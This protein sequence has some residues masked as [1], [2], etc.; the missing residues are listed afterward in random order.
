MTRTQTKRKLTAGL[1][2]L[3]LAMSL[4]PAHA[5]AEGYLD[6][7]A[8]AWYALAVTGCQENGLMDPIEEHAFF[9]SWMLTR[10]V[11]AEALYR[12]EGR[13]QTEGDLPFTDVPESHVN[14]DA[15]RWAVQ[16]G[17][18]SGYPDGTF[19][20]G[21]P[22]RREET[23]VL[24]W[25]C[26]GKAEAE[27]ETY[28]DQDTISS[29]ALP[30][31]A[32]ARSMKV[33]QGTD[34]NL[35]QPQEYTTRAQAASLLMGYG[36]AFYGLALPEAPAVPPSQD[37]DVPPSQNTDV[38][39]PSITTV[40]GVSQ[41]IRP[42]EYVNELFVQDYRGYLSYMG[43]V[44]YQGVDVSA[45]QEDIDWARVAAAGT[46]F[47]MIRA[48][49][50]GYT[51]GTINK[52]AYF[53]RNIRGA[54]A[55][56][57]QV[58]VYFFSQAITPQEAQEEAYQLLEWIRGYDI[59]Y[60]VVFDWEVPS[61]EA[62]T[63]YVDGA[64]ATACARAFCQVVQNAGYIPMTYGSPKKIYDGKLMLDQLQDYPAFW[65][66]NYTA[67]RAPTTFLY[68]YDMWQYSSTGHVDG[69]QGDVDLNV[70]LTDWSN[71]R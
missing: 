9:P 3:I 36:T 35:F 5:A 39:P 64:T 19:R 56:G 45:H 52:D 10:G 34:Q 55:N 50:R 47:A 11:V 21:A 41:D 66:A 30:A 26:Q 31:V 16:A 46:D 28:L 37:T 44:S 14:A 70:C 62:R 53:E 61:D 51:A 67:G 17:V 23:A 60:P 71:W 20:P 68:H 59:T 57:L 15:I 69:I 25:S 7:P 22:I 8:D 54:L 24:L 65:L 43:G 49:F 58:G 33:M 18:V 2:A 6:V 32:W 12:L 1:T 13:P 40:P 38:P 48:G 29:W 27:A 42:N 4:F 63:A